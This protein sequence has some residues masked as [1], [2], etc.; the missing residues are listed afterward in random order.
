MERPKVT[1]EQE[2]EIGNIVANHLGADMQTGWGVSAL[3]DTGEEFPYVAIRQTQTSRTVF[4]YFK[5]DGEVVIER[6]MTDA[7]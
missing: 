2:L 4:Y 3:D 7:R 1:D 6:K 5:P